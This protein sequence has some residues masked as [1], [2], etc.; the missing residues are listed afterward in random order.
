MAMEPH[1]T[2]TDFDRLLRELL[3]D[4]LAM[5]SMVDKSIERS[6]E[7]LLNRDSILA[8]QV[9]AEDE[10]IDKARFDIEE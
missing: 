1:A 2:R 3:D 5:G 4:V 7:A 9:V 10:R 8:Q 6:L